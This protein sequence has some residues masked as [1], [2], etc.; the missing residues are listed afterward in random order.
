MERVNLDLARIFK[1]NRNIGNCN[2][3]K[4]NLINVNCMRGCVK[5]SNN[6][7]WHVYKNA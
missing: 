1:L 4:K 6:W 2:Q 3:Q 7:I 5:R